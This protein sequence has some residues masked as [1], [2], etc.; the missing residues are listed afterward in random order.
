MHKYRHAQPGDDFIDIVHLTLVDR[1]LLEV[2]VELDALQSRGVD[3]DEL[4]LVVLVLGVDGAEPDELRMLGDLS[5]DVVV[6]GFHLVGR[7]RRGVHDVVVDTD[8]SP[9]RQ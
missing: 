2:R 9:A 8:A 3:A 7:C 4:V 5:D 6:D 1:E